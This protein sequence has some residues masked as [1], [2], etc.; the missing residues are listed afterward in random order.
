M[1][2]DDS[3]NLVSSITMPNGDPA[4]QA[5]GRGWRQVLDSNGDPI[6]AGDMDGVTWTKHTIVSDSDPS[7]FAA[8]VT[9]PAWAA[10]KALEEGDLVLYRGD[11][12]RVRQAHTAQSDWAPD[13]VAARIT[14]RSWIR[15]SR[16]GRWK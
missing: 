15:P 12:W 8:Q 14:T 11:V 1:D 7:A 4:N 5:S 6:L 13:I 3:M 9:A 16:T 10:G 2:G